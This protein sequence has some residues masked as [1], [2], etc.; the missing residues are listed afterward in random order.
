MIGAM[1]AQASDL[2]AIAEHVAETKVVQAAVGRQSEQLAQVS[3]ETVVRVK[4]ISQVFE[5]QAQSLG[6]PTDAAVDRADALGTL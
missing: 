5:E 1:R 6:W 3:E 4:A 2:S